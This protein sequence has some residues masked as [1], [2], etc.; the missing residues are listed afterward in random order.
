MSTNVTSPDTDPTTGP[1]ATPGTTVPVESSAPPATSA[2]PPQTTPPAPTTAPAPT[3]QAPAPATSQAPAPP[4]S[5]APAPATSQPPSPSPTTETPIPQ[6]PRTTLI[7]STIIITPTEAG[8]KTSTV[9]TVITQTQ[10][11]TQNPT[12]ASSSASATSSGGAINSGG[13]SKSG[14][15]NGGTIA[16][17]VVVPIA[18]VAL[19]ILAGLY[20]WRKRK[21]RKDAEEE[22]RKEVEDYAYNPNADPTIPPLGDGGSYEMKEDAAS[23]GYRGWGSTTLAGS[24]GRKASTT[25]SGGNTGAAYSDTTPPTRGTD[26]YSGEPLINEGSHS[27]DGEILG[28]MGPSAALNRGAGVQRGPSNASSS[29]SAGNHSDTS[30]GIGM[31]YGGG[32]SNGNGYY[33]QYANNPYSEGPYDQRATELPGQPVIR[34]NPARRNTR[35]ENPSHYPQQQNAGISQ[36]F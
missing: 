21:Q 22:R 30:D 20:F 34:D 13:S 5:Q 8:G 27:P 9:F 36:N 11:V 18:A 17:A 26:T 31:A 1:A 24:T 32:N 4:T 19:L 15:G 10:G 29:Y 7:V 33:D 16:V 14:L 6:P 12:T 35:I 28:A 23:S 2:P 3:T 25:M